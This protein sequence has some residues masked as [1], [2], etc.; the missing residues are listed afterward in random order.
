MSAAGSKTP[1]PETGNMVFPPPVAAPAAAPGTDRGPAPPAH[2]LAQ[3]GARKRGH[4]QRV[5]GKD[6]EAFDQPD[7]GE[8]VDHHADLGGQQR[9]AHDLQDRLA[10]ASDALQSARAPGRD[11]DHERREEPVADHDDHQSVVFPRNMAR[12]AVLR[13]EDEARGD[14]QPDAQRGVVALAHAGRTARVM[15][16]FRPKPGARVTVKPA[17]A[18]PRRTKPAAV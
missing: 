7:P 18:R 5:D 16:R 14:H 2:E 15:C 11:G 8:G 10:R 9:A 1:V 6:R 13:G 17:A 12:D 4:E 3:H